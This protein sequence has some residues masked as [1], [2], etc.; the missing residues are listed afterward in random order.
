MTERPKRRGHAALGGRIVAA[1]LSTGAAILFAGTIADAAQH[2]ASKAST[3][4]APTEVVVHVVLPDG[5][6]VASTVDTA[7]ALVAAPA[8]AR[9]SARS[10]AS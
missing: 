5:R 9:T 3:A 7:P 2:D 1:G 8:T 4:G 10:R 6:N